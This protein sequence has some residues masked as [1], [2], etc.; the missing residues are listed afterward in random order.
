MPVR[1]SL[2]LQWRVVW[3]HI[4]HSSSVPDIARQLC[5]SVQAVHAHLD[6]HNIYKYLTS[7]LKSSVPNTNI[8]STACAW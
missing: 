4:Q 7:N 8:I 2:D 6:M 5:L 3:L 1:Y